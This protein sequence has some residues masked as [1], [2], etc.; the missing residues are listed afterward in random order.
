MFSV[1]EHYQ[2]TDSYL[3]LHLELATT[4]YCL[5][6]QLVVTALAAYLCSRL[7][8]SKAMTALQP[9]YGN[10]VIFEH[11]MPFDVSRAYD[12]AKGLDHPRIWTAE[13]DVE[14]LLVDADFAKP[15][16]LARL[17]VDGEHTGL[18]DILADPRIDPEACVIRTDVPQLSLLAAGKRSHSDTELLASARTG[19]VLDRLLAANPKRI[20]VFDSPPALAASPA[21]VL[22]LLVGQVMLVVRADRTTEGDVQEAVQLLDGCDEIHLVLNAVTYEPGRGRFGSYYGRGE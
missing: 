16:V 12:E 21:S 4:Q 13:R 3:A 11:C 20:I 17:G 5:D 15:D 14:I 22:A 19:E 1:L 9:R 6:L 7:L 8:D 2:R 18:L 10:W